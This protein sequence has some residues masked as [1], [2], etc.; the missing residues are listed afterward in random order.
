MRRFLLTHFPITLLIGFIMKEERNPL[1]HMTNGIVAMNF[2]WSKGE[3]EQN[4]GPVTK[5]E[6]ESRSSRC[7][8][9]VEAQ[10]VDQVHGHVCLGQVDD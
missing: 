4:E 9:L 2:C 5:I 1:R 6:Y 3:E 8:Y 10:S 7:C